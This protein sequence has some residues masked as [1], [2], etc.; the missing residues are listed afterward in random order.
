MIG[1]HTRHVEMSRGGKEGN[2]ALLNYQRP[3]LDD[4]DPLPK[5]IEDNEPYTKIFQLSKIPNGR[6]L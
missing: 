2:N 1:R 5:L 4:L 3:K 6:E